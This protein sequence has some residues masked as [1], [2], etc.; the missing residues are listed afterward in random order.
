MKLEQKMIEA[1]ALTSTGGDDLVL[2]SA[3]FLLSSDEGN[4]WCQLPT[5]VLLKDC[6]QPQTWIHSSIAR[7]WYLFCHLSRHQK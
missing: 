1:D 3:L 4:M 2:G 6:V 5:F 7:E